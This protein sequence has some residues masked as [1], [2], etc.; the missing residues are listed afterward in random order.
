[1]K[2]IYYIPFILFTAICLILFS[3]KSYSIDLVTDTGTIPDLTIGQLQNFDINEVR[4]VRLYDDEFYVFSIAHNDSAAFH[5]YGQ[6]GTVTIRG[7]ELLGD[8]SSYSLLLTRRI[9]DDDYAKQ[10]Y[11]AWFFSFPYE[12]YPAEEEE[13]EE[14]EENNNDDPVFNDVDLE[15]LELTIL[16]ISMTAFSIF[17]FTT[18]MTFR[19]D[20]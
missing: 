8:L 15:A 11:T 13:E 19:F 7:D 2:I 3:N 14:E 4:H 6:P 9:N 20:S 12:V 18:G 1:M 17:G 5:W 10:I 16:T